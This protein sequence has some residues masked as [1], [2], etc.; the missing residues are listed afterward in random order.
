MK[1]VWLV[2]VAAAGLVAGCASVP[3]NSGFDGIAEDVAAK[4][5]AAP[6]W[7]GVT[8]SEAEANTRID[9]LLE[10]PLSEVA[11]IDL[12]L[13]NNRGLRASYLG[14][15]AAAGDYRDD[16]SLPNPFVSAMV[17]EVEDEPV[18]NL[19][20][21]IGI[22]LLDILF[23]PRRMK[24]A[25]RDFDAAQAATARTIL[26]FIAEVRTAYYEV[27]A[28]S[29]IADL[30]GQAA[31]ASEASADVADA[32]FEAGNIAEVERDR[33]RFLAAQIRLD[34]M[35]AEADLVAAREALNGL[36]GLHGTDAENWII[37]GRLRHAPRESDLAA[38]PADLAASAS[39]MLVES[40]ARMAAAGARL[41]IENVSS[42]IGEIELEAER[43]RDDGEYENGIGGGI[44]LPLFNWGGGARQAAGA[45]FEAM[46]QQRIADE[47]SLRAEAR[48]LAA[49]L[50]AARR[51]ADYQRGEVLPLAARVLNGAQLDY[52]AMQIGVFSL[53]D[54]K[55][56][57]LAA[58][59]G[60]VTALRD[61]WAL[62]ARYDQMMAGGSI[63]STLTGSGGMDA[64]SADRGGH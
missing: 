13:L 15:K 31:E 9:A 24:A 6:V 53:L 14:L 38:N 36:L 17:F 35:R 61:Y 28:A 52:N 40:D 1:S 45:R 18:T 4:G 47:I 62:R 5:S 19:S 57:Q 8:L 22:E 54:A 41:G 51:A 7:P 44:E 64:G 50:E 39:L 29:Q 16:A 23:L 11:A 37:A 48:R 56:G 58:G 55:R 59:R 20:Y 10:A 63:G 2:S 12:A 43:E 60:Y 27:V 46:A 25:G 21:G 33:E 49:E 34:A 32:L 3:P 26:D 30:M 42:L